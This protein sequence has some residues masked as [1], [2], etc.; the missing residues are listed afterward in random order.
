MEQEALIAKALGRIDGDN[1]IFTQ[2]WWNQLPLMIGFIASIVAITLLTLQFPKETLLPVQ[3]TDSL[4]KVPYLLPIPFVLLLKAAFKVYNERFVLTPEYMIHVSG[5]LT[6]RERSVRLE[7]RRIQ[8]IETDHTILQRIFNLGDVILIPIAGTV[9]TTAI[10]MH[11]VAFPQIIKDI[12][13]Q[14][15]NQPV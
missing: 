3:L 5:R 7:Y 9:Q 6:W 13:R 12:I 10:H 11:G 15:Q 14:R 4:I 2:S 8:E 1:V